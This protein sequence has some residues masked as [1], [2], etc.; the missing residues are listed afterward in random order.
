M[1]WDTVRMSL[2]PSLGGV[3]GGGHVAPSPGPV[4]VH[5]VAGRGEQLVRVGSEIVPLSLDQIRW[6][7]L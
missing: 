3:G 5:E 1:G 4:R 6:K 7:L 2:V